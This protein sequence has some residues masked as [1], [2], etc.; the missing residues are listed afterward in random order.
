MASSFASPGI[1]SLSSA[2]VA[3]RMR[4]ISTDTSFLVVLLALAS[5]VIGGCGIRPFGG[6]DR[7]GIGFAFDLAPL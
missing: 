1:C 6:G 4:S 3:L 2:E 7:G 5:C